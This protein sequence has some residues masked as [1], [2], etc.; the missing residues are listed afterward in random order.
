MKKDIL[1]GHQ[2]AQF[3][4]CSESEVDARLIGKFFNPLGSTSKSAI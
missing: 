3:I 4:N 1:I 2:E